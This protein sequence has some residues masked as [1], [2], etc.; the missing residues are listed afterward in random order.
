MSASKQKGTRAE[1][2]VV[3]CLRA[4]GYPDA[5]RR[6]LHGAADRGD[7]CNVPGT[8]IEV[9]DCKTMQLAGWVDEANVEAANNGTRVGVVWHHRKGRGDP[10]DWYVTMDGRTFLALLGEEGGGSDESGS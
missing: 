8:T 10:L 9:K 2:A 4:N 1:S 3:A 5:E 6:V 7:I